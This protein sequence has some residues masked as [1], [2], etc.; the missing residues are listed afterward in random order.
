MEKK[1][2]AVETQVKAAGEGA[3]E[4]A[5]QRIA[6]QDRPPCGAGAETRALDLDLKVTRMKSTWIRLTCCD[7]PMMAHHTG[8]SPGNSP[9]VISDDQVY[10]KLEIIV[11]LAENSPSPN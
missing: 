4:R 2:T 8:I 9:R 3:Q 11:T 6:V 1:W 7:P 10:Y 5:A